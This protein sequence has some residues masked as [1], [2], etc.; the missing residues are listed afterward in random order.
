MVI[1]A[2]QPGV[3]TDLV[4]ALGSCAD[5]RSADDLDPASRQVWH[6]LAGHTPG[7]ALYVAPASPA[8]GYWSRLVIVSEAHG[9]QF[10]ALHE[11]LAPA[12]TDLGAVAA[13][14]LT[15]RGLHGYHGREW[16]AA[17]GNLHLSTAATVRLRAAHHAR[18]LSMLPAVSVAE[19][20]S[21][22]TLGH[23][24]PAI[25]WVNDI[26]VG[27]RKVGG[28]IAA[29]RVLGDV[30]DLAVFGVGLNVGTAPEVDATPFVPAAGCLHGCDGGDRVTLGAA[31]R[32]VLE[33]LAVR[34]DRLHRDGPVPLQRDYRRWS[35]TVGRRVRVWNDRAIDGV[36][37]ARWPPAEAAG[38][39]IDIGDDLALRLAGRAAPVATGRLAFEEECVPFGL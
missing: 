25:K 38:L 9:S 26:V 30:I 24:R 39:V 20:I 32:C 5:W 37:R 7:W 6:T 19:A 4:S 3:M 14:A 17:P 16:L 31:L 11:K 1:L 12:V 22:A 21:A 33:R 29:S 35:N 27:S 34:L 18:S 2:D 10:D 28:A 15:G 13:L 23:V 8:I 36:D